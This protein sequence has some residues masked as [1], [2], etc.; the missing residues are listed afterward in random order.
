MILKLLL[1]TYIT[2]RVKLSWEDCLS[3]KRFLDKAIL[4]FK[5]INL[6]KIN[7]TILPTEENNQLYLS[8]S[9]GLAS[10][11]LNPSQFSPVVC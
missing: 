1:E 2:P 6:I 9:S 8:R 3:Q 7:Q 10:F 5:K 4:L 11:L